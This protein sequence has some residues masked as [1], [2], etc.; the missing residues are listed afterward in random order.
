MGIPH[1]GHITSW[2]ATGEQGTGCL[3]LWC[4]HTRV[5]VSALEDTL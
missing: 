1:W 2:G 4:A 3:C 5:V